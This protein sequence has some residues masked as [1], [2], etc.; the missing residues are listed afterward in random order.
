MHSVGRAA[1]PLTLACGL[2]QIACPGSLLSPAVPGGDGS[3]P[4]GSSGPPSA[5]GV[6]V[7]VEGS[8]CSPTPVPA[9]LARLSAEEYTASL[10]GLV[11]DAVVQ[12]VE[13]QLATLPIDDLE[14]ESAFG[15]QDQ[16]LSD[17]HVEALF[18]VAERVA[19]IVSTRGELRASVLGPC[20]AEGPN[21]DCLADV[22][23]AFFERALRRPVA[24]DELQDFL[25]TV[26]DF[27]D[28]EA[29]EAMVFLA[30]MHPDFYYRFEV[31]GEA[32]RG[33]L[34]LD[35]FELA[36]RLSYHFW[37]QPPDDELLRAAR[38]G[39]LMTDAGYEAQVD[40]L[41]EDSR[42]E[43]TLLHFFEEW[44]HLERGDFADS[45]RLDILRDGLETVGLAEAMRDE[46]LALLTTHLRSP[47]STWHDV[48]VDDRSYARD[49]RLA[50][51]YGVE[52][53]DGGSDP[54][55]LPASERSGLLSR[56]G[57]LYT[58]DG[59]TNPFRRGA[60]VRR[61]LLCDDVPPPPPDLPPDALEPP[62]PATGISSRD[63][64]QVLVQD[65]TCAGCH[66]VF[67]D[68]GYVMEAYDGLG[69]FRTEERL[70]TA[71]GE[72]RG[73][74][75]IDSR[76]TPFVDFDDTRPV[77]G[78]VELNQRLVESSKTNE[79]MAERYLKFTLR[80]ELEQPDDCAVERLAT[81]LE[82]G[83]PMRD[84][85]RAVALEPAFR[86]RAVTN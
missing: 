11:G 7:V 62:E 72:D 9:P 64:F 86:L 63:A 5:G 4:N 61:S 78:P 22:A 57:M 69:R 3:G 53:W 60:F 2:S 1:L 73:T 47:D 55:V 82:T 44:L 39:E 27:V 8:G 37:Q 84:V 58:A 71:S 56:A 38:E 81:R 32:V 17:R 45:P 79:C 41:F 23:P 75:F 52:T 16:R 13:P 67:S 48:L 51:V 68:F 20:A 46:V 31:R 21:M 29:V 34:Q 19:A 30:L 42:T 49:P 35:G 85:L 10:R 6:D 36:N 66:S 59:S 50:Q 12:E 26:A 28:E 54:P 24:A 15:R 77:S 65:Q 14:D 43:D 80:R 76:A 18:R 74:A 70:V 83:Q 40:R 33:G 25:T